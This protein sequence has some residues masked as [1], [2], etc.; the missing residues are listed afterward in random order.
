M[1]ELGWLDFGRVGPSAGEV[2]LCSI[3]EETS[4]RCRD[5]FE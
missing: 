2:I 1:S 3:A 4:Q 5:Y